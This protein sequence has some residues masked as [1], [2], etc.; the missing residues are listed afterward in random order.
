MSRIVLAS[1][2]AATLFA[3]S[4]TPA[5]AEKPGSPETITINYSGIDVTNPEGARLVLRKIERAAEKVCGVRNGPKSIAERQ[6]EQECVSQAVNNA[7]KTT[8][9]TNERRAALEA[10]YA[11]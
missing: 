5:M 1:L 8:E 2:A 10:A 11:G 7:I 6:F 4:A 9:T 3:V